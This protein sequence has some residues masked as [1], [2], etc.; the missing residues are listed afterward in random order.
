MRIESEIGRYLEQQAKK[1]LKKGLPLI[2]VSYSFLWFIGLDYLPTHIDLGRLAAPSYFVAG[3]VFMY[4]LLQFIVP[5]KYF[6]SGLNGE[7]KVIDNIS[8]KLG[9][10]HSLFNDV[11]LKDGKRAG[12]IDHVI[13]GPRGI[14]ALETKN[15]EGNLTIDG[16]NWGIK[17]QPSIQAKNNAK[18]LYRL[19]KNANVL[20]RDIPLVHA[21]V[22]LTNPKV[23][24][25]PVRMPDM[26]KVVQIKDQ[27]D[28]GLR[29]CILSY[30]DIEYNPEEI[31]ILVEFLKNVT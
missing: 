18:R 28:D 19:L 31:G 13:V 11:M 10:E 23:K 14:F 21:I 27:L 15:I 26:C 17:Q 29:K 9:N 1:N 16:D 12:N 22:V 2:V 24:I 5:Y 20:D 6:K 30:E 7:R 8:S 4:G 25:N 3:I